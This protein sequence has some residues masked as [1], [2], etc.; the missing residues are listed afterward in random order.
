VLRPSHCQRAAAL[1]A[2]RSQ[3]ALTGKKGHKLSHKSARR[4]KSLSAPADL[5]YAAFHKAPAARP[6]DEDLPGAGQ[7]YCV[8]T[9][10]DFENA[11][12]LERHMLSRP[13]R[14]KLKELQTGPAPHT[15][16]DAEAAAGMGLPDNG[17]KRRRTAAAADELML[18]VAEIR[19]RADS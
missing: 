6:V 13:Y 19:D 2:R 16:L 5:V 14:R 12:A 3:L 7:F 10:R 4:A 9:G 8:V 17:R 1:A 15:Q 18:T 11:A